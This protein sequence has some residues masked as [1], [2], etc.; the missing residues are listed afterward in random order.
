VG[1]VDLAGAEALYPTHHFAQL[2]SF[3]REEKVPFT[4]HAGEADGPQSVACALD[5]GAKRIG[6]GVRAVQ[7]PCLLDRMAREGVTLELCPTSNMDTGLFSQPS[8]FPLRTLLDAGVKVS[9]NT[10]NR[11]VSRTD[12]KQEFC[13]MAASH[14]LSLEEQRMLAKNAALA[15]FADEKTKAELLRKISSL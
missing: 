1:A 10:D 11:T 14:A 9:L 5:F 15:S 13:R 6:H 4:V 8:E 2:F 3:L 7:D 12:L